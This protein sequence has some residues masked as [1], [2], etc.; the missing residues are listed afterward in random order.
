MFF[1]SD[2][3]PPVVTAFNLL[4]ASDALT[5]PITLLAA[6]DLD[7]YGAPGNIRGWY[8]SES[9][10]KPAANAAG[11]RSSKPTF[12]TFA[13]PGSK[14]LYAFVKDAAGNVSTTGKAA[15]TT[16]T[17]PDAGGIPAHTSAECLEY[18]RPRAAL[19][20]E[21]LIKPEY[22]DEWRVFDFSRQ[23]AVDETVIAAE[24]VVLC[25]DGTDASASM[26]SDVLP[27]Q[28]T[29]IIYKLKGGV[30]GHIYTRHFRV[31]TSSG[32]KLE[33]SAKLKVV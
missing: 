5:V 9:A 16:I 28:S 1:G 18:A 26:I 29:G 22:N 32:N 12:Y 27:Y 11:W 3:V 19:L 4:S 25:V 21:I 15:A 20:L 2:T 10:T 23:L 14:T 7:A 6:S 24:V 30:P 13:T 17:L 8:L 33:D 31:V